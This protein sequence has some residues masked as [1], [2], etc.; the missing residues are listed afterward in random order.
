[1]LTADDK[2]FYD[3]KCKASHFFRAGKTILTS[4]V[5]HCGMERDSEW[6]LYSMAQVLSPCSQCLEGYTAVLETSPIRVALG[7]H[8]RIVVRDPR[9]LD[10]GALTQRARGQDVQVLLERQGE[11][12]NL[13]KEVGITW[14]RWEVTERNGY[15]TA[16]FEIRG[17]EIDA[18]AILEAAT[19]LE[20]Q[21]L[22]YLE[23]RCKDLEDEVAKLTKLRRTGS[24]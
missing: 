2:W 12:I 13:T 24:L 1:M 9:S 20:R 17:V 18:D 4:M 7:S 23:Q 10:P 5:S 8:I 11:T 3:D 22:E 19:L 21:R 16:T 6:K 14:A 15:C